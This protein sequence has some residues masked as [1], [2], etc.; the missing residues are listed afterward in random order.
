M[1]TPEACSQCL[2]H[3]KLDGHVRYIL[4]Q[5]G[6]ETLVG[7]QSP[8]KVHRADTLITAQLKDFSPEHAC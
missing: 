2:I 3:S 8:S 5:R 4:Q 6:Q 7:V 1:E